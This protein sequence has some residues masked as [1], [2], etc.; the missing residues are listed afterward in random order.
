[1]APKK[2]TSGPAVTV[3]PEQREAASVAKTAGNA[4][5]SAGNFAE[6]VKQFTTAIENDPTD[7]VYYSNRRHA[8]AA[9]CALSPP[10]SARSRSA[11]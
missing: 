6:A 3:T 1:M 2:K 5:F 4:A 9:G 11:G 7:H 10:P 8:S